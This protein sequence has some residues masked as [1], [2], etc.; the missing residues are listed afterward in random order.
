MNGK[1]QSE[2]DKSAMSFNNWYGDKNKF[3]DNFRGAI[4]NCVHLLDIGTETPWW[5]IFSVPDFPFY[6]GWD[7][8]N[9]QENSPYICQRPLGSTG[10]AQNCTV[11][12]DSSAL[13]SVTS[14]I[15]SLLFAVM[16]L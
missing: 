16:L 11:F 14:S 13:P 7:D 1:W 4:E 3:G 15:L 6:G 2:L 12:V 8:L 10:E 9:C 5:F